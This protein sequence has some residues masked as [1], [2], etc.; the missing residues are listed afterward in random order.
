VREANNHRAA[1][2]TRSFVKKLRDEDEQ[3]FP[4][5]TERNDF[6]SHRFGF[7]DTSRILVVPFVLLL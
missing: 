2:T 3:A 6:L 4:R 7:P 5:R 1:T